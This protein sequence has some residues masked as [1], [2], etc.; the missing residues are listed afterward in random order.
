MLQ[1]CPNGMESASRSRLGLRDIDSKMLRK[2]DLVPA[3]EEGQRA[4]PDH[5]M[6]HLAFL[7][8]VYANHPLISCCTSPPRS[9]QACHSTPKFGLP[10]QR[11]RELG[12]RKSS[13]AR[14]S[15]YNFKSLAGA[16]TSELKR[17]NDKDST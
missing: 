6:R 10:T 2:I 14:F 17:H 11:K 7:E 15:F 5:H 4:L 3:S 12:E 1:I 8:R 13:P 16:V 9:T